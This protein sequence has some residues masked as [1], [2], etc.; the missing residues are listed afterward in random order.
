MPTDL[1]A[2]FSKREWDDLDLFQASPFLSDLAGEGA[3][4]KFNNLEAKENVPGQDP[5][6]PP[7]IQDFR[8]RLRKNPG[9]QEEALLSLRRLRLRTLLALARADLEN[10]VKPHQIRARL[11]A[12]SEAMVHGAWLVAENALRE[13]YVH[14]LILERRNVNPPLAICSLSR[15]GSGDPMYTTAPA[16]IFVHSRAAEFAPALTEK[17]FALARRSQKEWLPAREYFHRLAGRT[18]SYL[19]VP[20]PGGKGF[21]H[22][23]EDQDPATPILPGALVVL[24]SAFEAHFSNKRPLKERLALMRLR[25]LV[26]QEHLGRAVETMAREALLRTAEEFGARLQAG[27]NAWYRERAAVEGWPM[28]RG[29]LLDIERGIRLAQFRYAHGDPHFLTP[30][31]L[32]ALDLLTQRDAISADERLVLHRSYSWQWFLANRLSLLGLRSVVNWT[33]LQSGR[34]KD[35]GLDSSLGLPG[36][37]DRTI[38]SIRDA[39]GLVPRLTRRKTTKP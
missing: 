20:D 16:P 1:T 36:A 33:A 9:D 11:K 4:Y 35:D 21:G 2:L 29:G 10:R 12:L 32:K 18:M 5:A 30:S 37:T 3:F 34:I 24:L 14:P 38:K 23:A 27:I 28:I 8:R 6:S 13:K 17:D 19:S 25:F 31:P 15:L 26:G 39:Q 7:S 22:M